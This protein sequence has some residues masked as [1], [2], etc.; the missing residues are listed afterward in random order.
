MSA[1]WPRSW[2]GQTHLDCGADGQLFTTIGTN[3]QP[4]GIHQRSFQNIAE[5]WPTIWPEFRQCITELMANYKQPEPNWSDVRVLH[6]ELPD[7]PLDEGGEWSIGAVFSSAE[8]L[9]FLPY[10]G[11]KAL[12]E[13]AQASW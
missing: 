10:S 12:R 7:E 9:W 13:K 4:S 5:R 11:W 2:Q 6:L 8:M 1:E 3:S